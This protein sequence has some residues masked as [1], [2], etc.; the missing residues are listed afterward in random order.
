MLN[1]NR[2]DLAERFKVPLSQKITNASE[3]HARVTGLPGKGL[4]LSFLDHLVARK[5]F[6]LLILTG[7]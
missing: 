1:L 4:I 3:P 2:A 5:S 7:L 6:Q